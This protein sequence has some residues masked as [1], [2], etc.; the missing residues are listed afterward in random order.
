MTDFGQHV[1]TYRPNFIKSFFNIF[2][3]GGLLLIGLI[4]AQGLGTVFVIP[5]VI[6]ALVGLLLAGRTVFQLSSGI[7]LYEL[8]IKTRKG[9]WLYAE[10]TDVVEMVGRLSE[11]PSTNRIEQ[12]MAF[13]QGDE[14]VFRVSTDVANRQKLIEQLKERVVAANLLQ[15]KE[16]IN[17]GEIIEFNRLVTGFYMEPKPFPLKVAKDGFFL[18]DNTFIGWPMVTKVR[19]GSDNWATITGEIIVKLNSTA[20]LSFNMENSRES[21]IAYELIRSVSGK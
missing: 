5:G 18:A 6:L 4:I 12:G 2:I 3:A 9:Q 16:R 17:R 11:R 19:L 13:Y 1:A 8:G 14:I 20:V 21:I 7:S 10:I 15:L